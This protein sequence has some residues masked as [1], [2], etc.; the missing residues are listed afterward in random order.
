MTDWHLLIQDDEGSAVAVPLSIEQITLGREA[1]NL[2]RLTQRNVSRKHAVI[3]RKE[4]TFDYEDLGSSNGSFLNGQKIEAA[5]DLKNGDTIQIGDYVLQLYQGDLEQ[6]RENNSPDIDMKTDPGINLA[7]LSEISMEIMGQ[8]FSDVS[9]TYPNR[10]LFS[11][12]SLNEEPPDSV[13]IHDS[14]IAAQQLLAQQALMPDHHDG[15]LPLPSSKD[16]NSHTRVDSTVLNWDNDSEEIE[17]PLKTQEYEDNFSADGEAAPQPDPSTMTK[18]VQINMEGIFDT[19]QTTE[20]LLDQKTST[21]TLEGL[22]PTPHPQT[23]QEAKAV[24]TTDGISK[25][26]EASRPTQPAIPEI[27]SLPRLIITNTELA[28]KVFPLLDDN[29]T[30]GRIPQ[31]DFSIAHKSVSRRHARI[32]REEELYFVEDLE[33]VNGIV[34]NGENTSPM[35]LKDNDKIELGRVML[36]FCQA[37]NP[38]TLSRED[39]AKA[40]ASSEDSNNVGQIDALLDP[41]VGAMKSTAVVKPEPKNKVFFWPFVS[42]V[43]SSVLVQPSS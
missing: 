7:G 28:G 36:R 1:E 16:L 27:Q 10:Q 40:I 5:V 31:T 35:Q 13:F 12:S 2:I 42:S 43:S 37:G 25:E 20:T 34:V 15:T 24:P 8:N 14:L 22:N 9:G 19:V 41:L 3:T 29:V 23:T 30:M 6:L 39:I 17:T 26:I 33:S 11:W 38:F 21:E 18:T 4:D 32:Y